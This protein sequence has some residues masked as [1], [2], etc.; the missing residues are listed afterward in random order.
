[1]P[2]TVPPAGRELAGRGADGDHHAAGGEQPPVGGERHS[3][4]R[5]R[6]VGAVGRR[7]GEA[8]V[9][10]AGDGERLAGA[11]LVVAQFEVTD[12]ADGGH[13]HA[14]GPQRGVEVARR[15]GERRARSERDVDAARRGDDVH[16]D[17]CAGRRRRRTP[18]RL[19][20]L[21]AWVTV[22]ERFDAVAADVRPDTET[23]AADETADDRVR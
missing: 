3:V 15:L 20:W 21:A 19:A 1:M 9:V 4:D 2:E 5:A 16:R 13:L 6:G 23:P 10:A 14:R 17:L 22:I 8:D 11:E 7:A 18:T 12:R